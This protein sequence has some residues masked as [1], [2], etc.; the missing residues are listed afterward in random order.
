MSNYFFKTSDFVKYLGEVNSVLRSLNGS[1]LDTYALDNK[2]PAYCIYEYYKYWSDSGGSFDNHNVIKEKFILS[3]SP[4][5]PFDSNCTLKSS[6]INAMYKMRSFTIVIP[7]YSTYYGLGS[8][9]REIAI[10]YYC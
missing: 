8:M 10:V 5:G 7:L 6:C 9:E 1:F 4:Y 3:S 2:D